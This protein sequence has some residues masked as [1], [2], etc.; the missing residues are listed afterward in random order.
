MD[1][2]ADRSLSEWFE[3]AADIVRERGFAYG[4]PRDNFLRTYNICRALNIQLRDPSEL[5]LVFI[6]VKLSR[7]VESPMREDSIVD[8]IGLSAILGQLRFTDWSDFDPFA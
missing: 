4:D 1:D 6:A 7:L 5:A 2:L 3:I 8:L